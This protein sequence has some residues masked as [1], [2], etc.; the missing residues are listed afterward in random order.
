MI[1]YAFL[2]AYAATIPAANWLI[3]N[4]GTV[5]VPNG[6]CLIPVAPGI[7]SPSGVLLIGLALVLRDLVQR[8]LGAGWG[9]GAV[10][11][12][13]VVSATV[14]PPGLVLASVVAVLLSEL[15]DFLVYTPLARRGLVLAVAVSSVVGLLL[16]SLLFLSVAFG[17]LAHLDGQIIGK[18]LAV[19]AALPMVALLRQWLP[20]AEPAYKATV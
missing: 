15:A 19:A 12:G 20:K 2:A 11:I 1:G 17:S 8:C 6:P 4:V 14:A 7:M 5:C 9:L 3:Q 10:L 16:D 13:G 18:A